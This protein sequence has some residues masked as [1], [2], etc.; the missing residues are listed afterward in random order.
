MQ[1][2]PDLAFVLF[3]PQIAQAAQSPLSVSLEEDPLALTALR[4]QGGAELA[5]TALP[6]SGAGCPA[7]LLGAIAVLGGLAGAATL[8]RRLA[9]A[10]GHQEM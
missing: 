10:A 7:L 9:C 6:A 8:L 5:M 4:V 2:T 1:T 3:G